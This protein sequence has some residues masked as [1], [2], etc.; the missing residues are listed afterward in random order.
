MTDGISTTTGLQPIL[1][2][3]D[4]DPDQLSVFGALLETTQH[5]VITASS[6]EEALDILK[7]IHVEIIVCDLNMPGQT[8]P[9]L[10]SRLRESSPAKKLPVVAYS[11][12][13]ELASHALDAGANCFCSKTQSKQLVSSV[14]A[15]TAAANHPGRLLEQMQFVR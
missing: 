14:S 13:N 5:K 15:L 10:I 1:L 8:G 6:V 4:D 9:E 12:S 3:V 7:D 2:L 11:A